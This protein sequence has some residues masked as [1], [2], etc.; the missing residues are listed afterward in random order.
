MSSGKEVG[1]LCAELICSEVTWVAR[2]KELVTLES[3]RSLRRQ[4]S[5]DFEIPANAWYE[6]AAYV[7]LFFLPKAPALFTRFDLRDEGGKSLSLPTRAENANHSGW[8]LVALAEKTL[9]KALGDQPTV[10]A[11]VGDDLRRIALAEI[12]DAR[13]LVSTRF[14]RPVKSARIDPRTAEVRKV[15]WADPT[16]KWLLGAMADSSIVVIPFHGK[17]GARRIVKLAYD[18]RIT[19][20]V[21]GWWRRTVYELG[22]VGHLQ[23]ID[24]P[25]IGALNFHF[26]IHAPDGMHIVEA[27][28]LERSK[29]ANAQAGPE[30][31]SHAHF[32]LP[33]AT[34]QRAALAYI[35][36]RVRSAFVGSA[37]LTA[38]L[39]AAAIT[40]A[41]LAAPRLA[42]G[43]SGAASLLLVFPGAIAAYLS[44]PGEHP[45]TQRLLSKARIVL[46]I[47]ALL[48]LLAAARLSVVTDTNPASVEALRWWFAPLA[49]AGWICFVA[50]LQTWRKPFALRGKLRGRLV[51]DTV[52]EG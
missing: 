4:A 46:G 39:V 22:W 2:R 16:F 23:W 15:L 35:H 24:L 26:E 37:A 11:E 48:S 42:Q 40:T 36:F 21:R 50:L 9:Q 14:E 10:P 43:T 19:D 49:V 1:A 33:E 38:F 6:G 45:L 18:E 51:G 28:V 27:G 7:P 34:T 17:G 12:K 47:T 41:A 5:V 3:E 32:Y 31:T 25:F 52:S 8:A 13:R 29:P 30:V 44:R 20:Q